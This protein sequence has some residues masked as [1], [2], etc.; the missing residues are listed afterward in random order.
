[1]PA[2][3]D[4]MTTYGLVGA[5]ED[6]TDIVSIITRDDTPLYSRF[7]KVPA[8]YRLH[9]WQTDTLAAAANNN[10]IEGA[11]ATFARRAPRSR[12]SNVTQI[13]RITFSVS[14]TTEAIDIAGVKKEFAYQMQ[15]ALKELARS[16][17][18][19][20][21]NNTSSTTGSDTVARQAAGVPAFVTTVNLTS[22]TVR[23]L[24][25]P[26][27]NEALQKVRENGGKVDLIVGR[28]FQLRQIQNFLQTQGRTVQVVNG[29]IMNRVSVY[30]T[31]FGVHEIIDSVIIP[32]DRVYCLQTD[33]WAVAQLRPPHFKEI[34][35][36]G[37][38]RD[39]KVEVEFTLE[40]R[41]EAGNAQI[42]NLTTE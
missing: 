2:V 27:L 11:S 19:A 16:I 4:V 6:L 36:L 32:A 29:R 34:A 5:R 26:L 1:M 33:L 24:T 17:E 28:P 31:N 20:I 10:V 13:S 22:A 30:E 15:L 25:E 40:A 42:Q 9:E 35:Y 39:G 21:N 8:K 41:N 18:F 14:E 23:P 12:L 3:A 37:G 38:S 7:K